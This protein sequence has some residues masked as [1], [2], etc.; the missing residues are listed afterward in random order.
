M[1][2][3]WWHRLTWL[4]MPA[5]PARL[6][7]KPAHI[8][9][10]DGLR[11]VAALSVVAYHLLVAG[12]SSST[13]L[14]LIQKFVTAG[15]V[16][17]DLFFVLSGF[18]ITGIL[19]RSLEDSPAQRPSQFFKAFYSRRA[20]RIFPLYYAVLLFAIAFP[21]LLDLRWNGLQWL[22]LADLQNNIVFAHRSTRLNPIGHLWTLGLEEQFY[23]LWPLLVYRCRNRR[24]L[25]V[26][27]LLAC[28]ATLALRILL[29][30]HGV[31]QPIISN[32]TPCRLDGLLLGSSLALSLNGGLLA[33][34]RARLVQLALP[35]CLG[36][37]ATILLIGVARNTWAYE[38]PAVYTVGY[39]LLD[40]FFA[41]LIL[42]SL[43]P[44]TRLGSVL[45]LPALR[46]VGRYSYG[47]YVY[48]LPIA[49]W[50]TAPLRKIFDAHHTKLFGV[51]IS[52]VVVTTTSL[53][54][55]VCSYHLFEKRFLGWKRLFPYAAST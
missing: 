14:H 28:G 12:W 8:P 46:G 26:G 5:S 21:Y 16:G 1:V 34:A 44:H 2:V 29:W 54:V 24:R 20:L 25:L 45:S 3:P 51:L 31:G 19:V 9:A 10:L 36:A 53:L 22:Y 11:G 27:A 41:M 6:I 23:L 13:T 43:Q 35:L 48:H 38:D 4:K 33:Q 15:W 47:L 42:V 52:A 30:S 40:I 39:T 32:C 37:L 17:V 55:A 49:Y 18:L 7:D 50:L